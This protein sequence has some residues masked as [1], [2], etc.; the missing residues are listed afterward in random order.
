MSVFSLGVKRR[1]G[2]TLL[3]ACRDLTR[4]RLRPVRMKQKFYSQVNMERI[5]FF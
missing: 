3:L 1:V 4:G 5:F 2:L